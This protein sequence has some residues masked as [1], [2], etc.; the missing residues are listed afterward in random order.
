MPRLA[1]IG[2]FSDTHD[3]GMRKICDQVAESASGCHDVLT[4]QTRDFCS[5]RT[6]RSLRAFR[7]AALHYLTGPTLA[8]LAALKAH[9]RTLPGAPITIASGIRPYLGP[10]AR[11]VLRWVAPDV[12]LAQARRWERLFAAAGSRTI[13]WPNGVDTQRFAPVSAESRRALQSRLGFARDRPV[14]LHVGHVRENRNLACLADIQLAGRYQVWVVGSQS[15]SEPGPAHQGLVAAGCRVTT[16]YMPRIEEAYQAAA[17]YV[18]TV[19]PTPDGTYPRHYNEVGAI[20]FPLSV[21]E[22]MACNLPV[23]ATRHDAIAH[24]LGDTPG[25]A[26]FDG[27]GSDALRQLERLAG[28]PCETR[29]KAQEFDAAPV[30]ASL[31]AV[32]RTVVTRIAT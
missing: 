16:E 27:T 26:Y 31:E 3:E 20:D 7:P 30:M 1:L 28:R 32:Y 23:V 8:S 29:A 4:L 6:W 14:L 15:L 24:F 13:D 11:R 10:G 18:L 19:Q 17:A 22:A 21:L 2:T 9:Q 25:L 12:F 5:G